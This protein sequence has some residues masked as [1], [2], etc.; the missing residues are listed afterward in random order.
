M[1]QKA[2]VIAYVQQLLPN[3]NL[4]KDIALVMLTSN[5]LENL[6]AWIAV[7]IMEG[8][9]QY[10]KDVTKESEVISYARSMVMNHLKKAKELNG[11]QVYGV[12]PVT[13]QPKKSKVNMDLLPDDLK[14]FVNTLV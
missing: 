14:E 13:V 12:G 5:E 6:K 9:I 3:F 4:N 2:A 8:K 1:G 7:D 11:N 10:S